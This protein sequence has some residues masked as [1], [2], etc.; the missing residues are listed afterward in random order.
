[1]VGARLPRADRE[2]REARRYPPRHGGTVARGRGRPRPEGA[3]LR[4]PLRRRSADD[5]DRRRDGAPRGNRERA[6]LGRSGDGSRDDEPGGRL[7]REIHVRRP[8]GRELLP[9]RGRRRERPACRRSGDSHADGA[10]ARGRAHPRRGPGGVRPDLPEGAVAGPRRGESRPGAGRRGLRRLIRP[11]LERLHGRA[12]P[13]REPAA[14]GS[15][16][17]EPP[18]PLRRRPRCEGLLDPCRRIRR[19]GKTRPR[20][21]RSSRRRL[22][23]RRDGT[24]SV[25][26]RPQGARHRPGHR[27]RRGGRR[28]GRRHRAAPRRE[29]QLGERDGLCR[30]NG[31]HRRRGRDR[32]RLGLDPGLAVRRFR[33]AGPRVGRPDPRRRPDALAGRLGA[34]R[35]LRG[36]GG[37]LVG[38][39]P[40]DA[41]AGRRRGGP[42][43]AVGG[44]RSAP[45]HGRGRRL[46]LLGPRAWRVRHRGPEPRRRADRPHVRNARFR[47]RNRLRAPAP[48]PR[49]LAPPD[50]HPL[51]AERHRVGLEDRSGGDPLLGAS[52]RR[53]PA[54]RSGLSLLPPHVRRD[55]GGGNVVLLG[56]RGRPPGRPLHAHPEVREL[57]DLLPPDRRRS[58]G[59]PGS[60]RTSAHRQRRHRRE[61]HDVGHGRTARRR[62][63]PVVRAARRP[64]DADP[65]RLR[66]GPRPLLGA[67]A[68]RGPLRMEERSRILGRPPGD[69]VAHARGLFDPRGPAARRHL[70]GRLAPKKGLRQRPDGRCRQP[71]A[72]VVRRVPDL[73][74]QR[75]DP[76]DRSSAERSDRRPERVGLLHA[77]SGLHGTRRRHSRESLRR[78]RPGR[79]LLR[80]RGGSHPARL[81][82]RRRR[83][84]GALRVRVRRLLHGRRRDA[85]AVPRLGEGLRHERQPEHPGPPRHACPAEHAPRRVGGDGFGDG[86]RR[87]QDLRGLHPFRRGGRALR[88][89]RRAPHDLRRASPRDRGVERARRLR[90]GPVRRPPGGRLGCVARADVHVHAPDHRGRG[91]GAP[92]PCPGRRLQGGR[93]DGGRGLHRRR[94]RGRSGGDGSRR[95]APERRRRD[96][97]RH[98][99]DVRPRGDRSRRG[100]RG[101]VADRHDRGSRPSADA[102][103]DAGRDL[104]PLPDRP[105]DGPSLAHGARPRRR[106]RDGG[107]LWRQRRRRAAHARPRTLE[108]PDE[109][110]DR[111]ALAVRGRPLAGGLRVRRPGKDRHRS[112]APLPCHRQGRGRRRQRGPGLGRQRSLPRPD[113]RERDPRGGVVRCLSPRAGDG[114]VGLRGGL[115][116]AERSR[117]GNRAPIRG[118]GRGC[119]REQDAAE[120]PPA[121]GPGAPRLRSGDDLR[122]LRLGDPGGRGQRGSPRLP[123]R[124]HDPQP[125]PSVRGRPALVREPPSLLGRRAAGRCRLGR[126]GPP[127]DADRAG[128]HVLPVVRPVLPARSLYRR[129]ARDRPRR[130]DRRDGTGTPR[131]RRLSRSRRPS[132]R[133][134]LARGRR[135]LSRRDGSS[136][137]R[138]V[139]P[140]SRRRGK[141]VRQRPRA[142]IAGRRRR[143][144][145]RHGWRCPPDRGTVG[146]GAPF[147]RPRRGRGSGPGGRERRRGG[148]LGPSPGG[149]ARGPR[150]ASGERLVAEDRLARWER[151]TCRPVLGRTTRPWRHGP[152]RGRERPAGRSGRYRRRSSRRC[153]DGLP[154]TPR[155]G[156]DSAGPWDAPRL[157]PGLD[158]CP[159]V[160]AA[161]GA[162]SGGCH[163]RRRRGACADRQRPLGHGL[164]RGRAPRRHDPGARG[165]EPDDPRPSGRFTDADRRDGRVGRPGLPA[166]RR[167]LGTRGLAGGRGDFGGCR[168][169]GQGAAQ[170][171]GVRGT[172]LGEDRLERRARG[173]RRR[174][175]AFGARSRPLGAHPPRR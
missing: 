141:R 78:R 161:S 173:R 169:D 107:G 54:V 58:L 94:R 146:D 81:L 168:G 98:R 164:D 85:P 26:D 11:P 115:A 29:R 97:L 157:E 65:D 171:R 14:P 45:D 12:D 31:V 114:R 44:R 71:D 159:G 158:R 162:R 92:R 103:G 160:D 130:G 136:A 79:V 73:R 127:N 138:G 55:A 166:R 106:H 126:D 123:P 75:A 132:R 68:G 109:A 80:E 104:R 40:L 163:E 23:R 83:D 142:A 135:R 1:M 19:R 46:P 100:D 152:S 27:P 128:S 131:G 112:P 165:R 53:G 154:G 156:R 174:R 99:R 82:A 116:G 3:C 51:P 90:T 48:D 30:E 167:R 5:A 47:T 42:D 21:V 41:A 64:A 24:R 28:G 43:P 15:A 50:P 133:A 118:R 143:E 20:Q 89:R 153:G 151:W 25:Q 91:G 36:A 17:A 77:L 2:R 61:L 111:V 9:H 117:R 63:G 18:L 139:A 140:P 56:R 137:V 74:P 66:R 120:R 13:D 35:R 34:R 8:P 10:G 86:A 38:R 122:R 33:L 119:G 150:R 49:R 16:V 95:E 172:R 93:R 6:A 4:D 145:W 105:R 129:D 149:Q 62:D 134:R 121:G 72:R 147:R 84:G 59:R 101:E 76:L 70:H 96:L 37:R 125:L 170:L 22:V 60:R 155:R 110:C 52:P 108:R 148:R 39:G 7:A 67:A 124:R 113:R 57:D 144:P 87:G 69:G 32:L 102:R 88:R 175:P